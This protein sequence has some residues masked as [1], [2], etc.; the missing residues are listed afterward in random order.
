MKNIN[1]GYMLKIYL[2]PFLL[3]LLSGCVSL[4]ENENYLRITSIS[5]TSLEEGIQ[6]SA[7]VSVNDI[8][9]LA[10][11]LD[12]EIDIEVNLT[13]AK[14]ISIDG[15]KLLALAFFTNKNEQ[16]ELN[17]Q[18]YIIPVNNKPDYLFFPVISTF[19][20]HKKI[21]DRVYAKDSYSIQEGMLT[22]QYLIPKNTM[23]LLIHTAPKYLN[24]G[25]IDG[26]EG[27]LSPNTSYNSSNVDP[28][29]AVVAG[30]LGGAIGGA[31]AGAMSAGNYYET[32]PAE[33]YFFGP[34][35]VIDISITSNE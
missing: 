16:F 17:I 3:A 25:S 31:I 18:S 7:Y 34:G 32:A 27:G 28:G 11:P 26:K 13:T 15:T 5:K 20:S 29:L 8:L 6:A 22:S 1:R 33:N 9:D 4:L 10:V 35:G 19:D 24:I 21:I 12:N 30:I 23:Y 2:I 14:V